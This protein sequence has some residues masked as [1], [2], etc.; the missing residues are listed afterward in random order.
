MILAADIGAATRLARFRPDF[1]T[2]ACA[3]PEVL[4]MHFLM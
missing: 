4:Q 2:A 3:S 1:K